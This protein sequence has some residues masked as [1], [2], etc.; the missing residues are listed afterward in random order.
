MGSSWDLS[1]LL[2]LQEAMIMLI[3]MAMSYCLHMGSL[4]GDG[5]I[6]LVDI[7]SCMIFK[8]IR[9]TT[10]LFSKISSLLPISMSF[11]S[12]HDYMS[13]YA[14]DY[15]VLDLSLLFHMIKHKVRYLDEMMNRWLH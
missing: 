5:L 14:H 7:L 12:F 11:I 4:F 15:Y 8:M 1:C 3:G 6:E 2:S 13:I 9:I 10:T